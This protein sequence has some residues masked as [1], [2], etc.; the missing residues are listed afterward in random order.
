MRPLAAHRHEDALRAYS[1]DPANDDVFK[2]LR[3]HNVINR[4]GDRNMPGCLVISDDKI[5]LSGEMIA[6]LVGLG[7]LDAD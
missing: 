4:L 7:V 3:L 2:L 5:T 1:L 6:R